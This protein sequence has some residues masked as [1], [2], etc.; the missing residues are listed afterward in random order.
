VKFITLH[1]RLGGYTS[2]HFTEAHGLIAE[3]A[4]RGRKLELLIHRHAPREIVRA[5][6]AKAVFD[7]PTFRREWSFEERSDRFVAMLHEHVDRRVRAGDCVMTTI[8]T[9]LEAH[10]LTRWLVELPRRRKPWVVITFLSDR[11]NRGTR[12]EY[13]RQLA[14]FR[15]VRELLAAISTDDAH[16]L[17]FFAVTE[18]LAA[19]LTGML[20]RPV[21]YAPMPQAYSDPLPKVPNARPRIA[22]LGGMR[23]EKGSYLVPD[24]V[25]ACSAR[26]DVEFLVQLMNNSLSEEEAARIARI[27]AEPNV[28][29]IPDAVKQEDYIAALSTA[30]LALFPYEVIPYRQRTSGVFAES[31]V[32]GIPVLATPGTWMAQQIHAGRAAGIVFDE[33]TPEAI[34]RAVEQAVTTL[35]A[36][37]ARAATLADAWR[38]TISLTAYVTQVEHAIAE[39]A[40]T[41]RGTGRA[42][43][44]WRWW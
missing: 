7:D 15:K 10:A 36:L 17:L 23:A 19:E 29:V 18:P 41:G 4:R 26:L 25:R 43:G 22:V 21:D 37:R 6:G 35:D 3:C 27:A 28:V 9:Q 34:A 24:I 42:G 14:E 33:L 44:W 13:D 38:S 39:R 31:V 32:F 12:E 30:D 20:G 2:H 5:L 8:A 1:H 11:W 40:G 16:R